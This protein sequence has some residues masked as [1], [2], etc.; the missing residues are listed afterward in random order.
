MA[1]P[2][3]ARRR[4]R[5]FRIVQES[6]TNAARHA[7][8]SSVDVTLTYGPGSVEVLVED[9]GPTLDG[10]S[11]GHGLSGMAERASF[12]GGTFDAGPDRRRLPR[13]RLDPDSRGRVM[14]DVLI[15]DDQAMVRDGFAAILGVEED[16]SRRPAADGVE[17]IE[18][19]VRLARP[20]SS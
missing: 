14:I 2:S 7:A 6:L 15:A 19:A 13:A 3:G 18:A 10:P 20:T 1:A 11:P 5:C 8:G 17:A 9:D 16:S 12:V 4:A